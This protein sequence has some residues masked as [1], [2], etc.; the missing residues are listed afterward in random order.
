MRTYKPISTITYNTPEFLKNALDCQVALGNISFFAFI[1][2]K[3]ENGKKDHTHVYVEPRGTIDTDSEW[4]HNLLVEEVAS[5]IEPC[6]SAVPPPPLNCKP[7]VKSKFE[8][9][10][11]YG[12]H[13]SSYLASKQ[14]RREVVDYSPDCVVSSNA[15]DLSER[16]D[17]IDMERYETPITRMIKCAQADM[18]LFQAMAHLRIPY[19][20]MR[21][22]KDMYREVCMWV[23][24]DEVLNPCDQNGEVKEHFDTNPIDINSP[25]YGCK[26]DFKF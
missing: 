16:V 5:L 24:D 6:G 3:G 18:N 12:L 13:D 10:Y 17:A 7:W 15:D 1:S 20:C 26:D 9:W 4:W 11:L 14:M 22:F 23:G 21:T 19:A 25:A 8:D 2:H